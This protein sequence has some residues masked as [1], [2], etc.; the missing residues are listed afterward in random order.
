MKQDTIIIIAAAAA[1]LYAISKMVK[2]GATVRPPNGSGTAGSLNNNGNVP[3]AEINNT[4]LPGQP[5]WGWQYFSDGTAIS[6][7]GEY[8]F[9]GQRVW[10]PSAGVMGGV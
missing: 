6:P 5:G 9:N 10:S 3:V 7:A 1:G 2:P 8:Y 4:A